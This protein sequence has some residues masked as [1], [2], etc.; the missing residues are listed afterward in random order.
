MQEPSVF[1][2]MGEVFREPPRAFPLL[3]CLWMVVFLVIAIISATNMCEADNLK[4]VVLWATTFLTSVMVILTVKIWF[5]MEM[6]K[7]GH[8]EMNSTKS[9][10]PPPEKTEGDPEDEAADKAEKTE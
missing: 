5:L 1:K 6:N 8:W 10:E 9:R 2:I 7:I 4:S 3:A